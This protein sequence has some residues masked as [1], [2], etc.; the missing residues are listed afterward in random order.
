L[1]AMLAAQLPFEG[2]SS[3][4]RK[5]NILNCKYLS[6]A[7]LSIKAQKLFSTIFVDSKYRA[8]L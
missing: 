7:F 5:S 1:Y 6:P 8:K 3:E 4:K 2:D